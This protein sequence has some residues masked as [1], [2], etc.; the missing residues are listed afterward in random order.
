[1]NFQRYDD[2]TDAMYRKEYLSLGDYVENNYI[3]SE[4]I[5]KKIVRDGTRTFTC[6]K[7]SKQT[8]IS[9]TFKFHLRN[10]RCGNCNLYMYSAGNSLEICLRPIWDGEYTTI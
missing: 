1:M 5:P 3:K 9:D 6:P 2:Q 10:F 4:I 8:V 7:C